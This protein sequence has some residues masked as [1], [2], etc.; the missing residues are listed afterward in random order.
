MYLLT[1]NRKKET[2]FHVLGSLFEKLGG[3]P[4]IVISD[5]MKT[6]MDET[7]TNYS[8]GKINGKFNQFSKDYQFILK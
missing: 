3:V 1:L 7:R 8:S 2:L 6:I 4:K 5:N